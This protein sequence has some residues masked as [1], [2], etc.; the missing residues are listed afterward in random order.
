MTKPRNLLMPPGSMG[1]FHVVSRCVRREFLLEREG[2]RERLA[3]GLARWLPHVG[4][5]L[6]AYAL[7]S[8]HIHLVLRLRP[9]RVATWDDA[10][11]ARHALSV[12]PARSGLDRAPLPLSPEVVAR[13]AGN[14]AWVAQQRERLG[15]ASWL[16]RLVKQEM[17]LLA[18]RQEGC[19]GHFWES[20]YHCVALLDVPAVIACMIYVDLNP[21]RAGAVTV[22]ELASWCSARHRAAQA[23]GSQADASVGDAALGALLTPISTCAPVCPETGAFQTCELDA[24]SYLTALDVSGRQ[25]AAGKRGSI[26]VELDGILDRLGFAAERWIDAMARGGAMLGTALGA[27]DARQ[28][29]AA[30]SGTTWCADASRLWVA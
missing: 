12:M 25:I 4:V 1:T 13:H 10:T 7:M 19:S 11:L 3:Q 17:A 22:P 5:D 26:P 16:L 6:Q 8:N 23:L 14:A 15:S 9:D 27:P 29:F 2:R 28:A 21:V 24:R 20:R 30:R 18:N